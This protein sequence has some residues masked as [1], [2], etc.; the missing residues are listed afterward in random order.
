MLRVSKKVLQ[1]TAQ[2]E[3]ICSYGEFG[4]LSWCSSNQS[5]IRELHSTNSRSNIG[6]MEKIQYSNVEILPCDYLM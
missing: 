6:C 1:K 3:L 4:P 2:V 5:T